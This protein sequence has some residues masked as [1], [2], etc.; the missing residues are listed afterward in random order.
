MERVYYPYY[1]WEDYLNG[2]YDIL[3]KKEENKDERGHEVE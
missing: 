2:M 3:D 1:E